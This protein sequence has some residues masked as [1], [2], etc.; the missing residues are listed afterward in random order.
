MGRV[1]LVGENDDISRG[2]E[3]GDEFELLMWNI[4][5][6]GL[7]LWISLSSVAVVAFVFV[8]D[9]RGV[10]DLV[11]VVCQFHI[12]QFLR[13]AFGNTQSSLFCH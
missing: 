9:L 10:D 6:I 3:V 7:L 2:A 8:R 5:P 1:Y 4:L 13:R 12:T 11:W